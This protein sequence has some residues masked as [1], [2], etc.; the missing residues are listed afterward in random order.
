MPRF[1]FQASVGDRLTPTIV[2]AKNAVE[3][4]EKARA[5]IRQSLSRR[6][7]PEP[8]NSDIKLGTATIIVNS[9]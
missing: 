7:L 1:E 5:R 2:D 3:A 6:G 9:N 4:V 8:T